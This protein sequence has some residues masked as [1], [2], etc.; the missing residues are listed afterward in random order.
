MQSKYHKAAVV[1]KLV[2]Q[3]QFLSSDLKRDNDILGDFVLHSDFAF[4]LHRI[5]DKTF[6]INGATSSAI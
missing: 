1:V 4:T 3:D 2:S 6:Y 5:I